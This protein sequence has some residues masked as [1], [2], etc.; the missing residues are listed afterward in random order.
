VDVSGVRKNS[1]DSGYFGS[2]SSY[3]V[4]RNR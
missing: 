4:A 1:N 3:D 2:M